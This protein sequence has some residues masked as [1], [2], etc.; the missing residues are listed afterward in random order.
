MGAE[1]AVLG[2][3][4]AEAVINFAGTG[5][6]LLEVSHRSKEVD[7]MNLEAMGLFKE[8][9]DIPDGYQVLFLGGGASTQF[10]TIPYQEPSLS[11]Q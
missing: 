10:F 9:L 11:C 2:E 5:L 8:L 6:S 4:T 1:E 7:A 3:K